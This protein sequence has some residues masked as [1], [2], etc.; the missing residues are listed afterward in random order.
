MELLKLHGDINLQ[1]P[2]EPSRL[3]STVFFGLSQDI[4]AL[5]LCGVDDPCAESA[6]CREN[7]ESSNDTAKGNAVRVAG[8][9]I[10]NASHVPPA[11]EGTGLGA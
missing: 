9:D 11:R 8:A 1:G 3:K 6:M 2:S 4:E 5:I 7:V 10:A